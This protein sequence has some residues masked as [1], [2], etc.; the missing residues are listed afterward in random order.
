M[1][2]A[3]SKLMILRNGFG[4]D[5]PV[6][7]GVFRLSYASNDGKFYVFY[8]GKADDLHTDLEP[9]K[10]SG[11]SDCVKRAIEKY[12]VIAVKYAVVDD[13]GASRDDII[14]TLY[15]IYYPSCN[16]QVPEGKH[17]DNLST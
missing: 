6:K 10:L 11:L 1:L 17:I 16:T 4:E 7:P 2:L 14:R 13:G 8:V 9:S 3:W 15:D 12:P 5:I